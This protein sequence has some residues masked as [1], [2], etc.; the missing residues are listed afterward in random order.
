MSVEGWSFLERITNPL[1]KAKE[2]FMD[3]LFTTVKQLDEVKAT[4]SGTPQRG[5]LTEHGWIKVRGK[6]IAFLDVGAKI[7][8]TQPTEFKNA[9]YSELLAV[10]ASA[11][12]PS[13][14][15]PAACLAPMSQARPAV[16]YS[17]AIK[18][19][20]YIEAIV[21]F[22]KVA[23]LMESNDAQARAA[24]VNTFSIALTNGKIDMTPTA[25]EREPGSD[26]VPPWE[27]KSA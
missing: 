18:I 27:K 17:G 11:P 7:E 10:G 22:H 9:K 15:A 8:I 24:I 20:A 26:D 3:S 12:K 4:Q 25:P 1:T 21:K 14:P 2:G 6:S 5:V 23:S 13:A 16:S 19:E